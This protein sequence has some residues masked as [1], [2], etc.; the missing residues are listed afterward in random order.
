MPYFLIN[1]DITEYSIAPNQAVDLM[2]A[3]LAK[4]STSKISRMGITGR[5]GGFQ[6]LV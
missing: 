2:F 3:R 1:S 6:P 4:A 5:I